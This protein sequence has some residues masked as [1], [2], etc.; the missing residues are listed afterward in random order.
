MTTK[1]NPALHR[2]AFFTACATFC[3]V[4]AG[5]LVTSTGSGLAV[6]DWPLSYGQVMPPMVGG[7][8]YEHGHRMVATFVGLLTTILALWLWRADERRWVRVLGFAALGAVITQGVLGGLTVL[9]LLPTPVSVAHATLAQS[10]FSLT[11]F[12]ALVTSRLWMEGAPE[13]LPA[14]GKTRLLILAA[15]GAVFLQL[16]LGAWMRHSDAGLAIP[17]FPLSYGRLVPP[18]GSG[19][20]SWIN[21]QRLDDYDLPPVVASQVW[22]HFAH[23][24]GA[25][26]AGIVVLA[27]GFHVLR[28]HRDD[29]RL[30]EPAIVMIMLGLQML[31]VRFLQRFQMTMPKSV[32]RYIADESNFKGRYMPFTLGALT[33]FIPCGFCLTAQGF[34]LLS[35]KP[36]QGA[37]IM[38]FFALGTLP[39]LLIIAFSSVKFLEKPRTAETFLKVAGVLV[40]FFALFNINNQLVVL[41]APNLADIFSPSSAATTS[42]KAGTGVQ[43]PPMINGKQVIKMEASSSG[44]NPNDFTVR[45]G[46]PVR[47]EITDTGTTGCTS[48]VISADLFGGQISLAHGTTSSKEFTPSKPGLYRFSCWMGMVTGVI[49]VVDAKTT[50]AGSG[51]TKSGA[52]RPKAP[53]PSSGGC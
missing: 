7:I 6:P 16:V 44:Y 43:L 48:A 47:W 15:A 3:L 18:G 26:L 35:G 33:F 13:P 42:A 46:V 4:I 45:A 40:L 25:L 20:L 21:E 17:D 8:F 52:A 29:R 22:I 28:T 11:V 10:F 36:W 51:S 24:A 27:C 37:L 53:T 1:H 14:A 9:F 31:G 38:L 49:N 23:R 32:S 12:L 2:F 39:M 34:A 50:R 30:R 41:N 5:G 19:G